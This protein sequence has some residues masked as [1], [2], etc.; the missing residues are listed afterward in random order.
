MT[1]Q[2]LFSFLFPRQAS[3]SH[4]E[5]II[6]G[7]GGI[8][9]ILVTSWMTHIFIGPVAAPYLLAA[10]GASTVLLLGAP[11]S[12]F[13]Q[14]WSFAGGH[15][16]SAAIGITCALYLQNIYLAAGLAVGLSIV[17]MYYLR[18]IHPPGGAT[19]LLTVI[20]DQKIHAMGYHFIIMPVLANV[21]ILLVV[22]LLIN[23]LILRRQYPL[24][25]ALSDKDSSREH[26]RPSVKLSFS[27]EDLASAMKEMNGYIDVT[28]EDLQKIYSLAVV[29]SHQWRLGELRLKDIMTR[30]VVTIKPQQS[31][32][33]VWKLLRRHRI[34]G[35]PVV[36]E[37]N[38][39]LG[40]VSI[41][42]FL[43]VADWRMC[44]TLIARMKLF[45]SNQSSHTV[46]QIMSTPVIVGHENMLLTQAFQLFSEK[47]INHLPLV[48]ESG[49]LVGILTRLD[50]LSSLYGDMAVISHD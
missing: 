46:A 25:L 26:A 40:I 24:N 27:Q 49:A 45:F 22:A 30:E 36:D 34:R 42:D 21:A 15:L 39:L 4:R 43:E 6:S 7:L 28:G 2:A 17:A 12:P 3:L 9:A 47:G 5:R 41:A 35:A 32:E 18:C 14:P 38:K 16:V 8:L 31:L 50:L 19:A 10:M 11:H 1:V 33:D 48:D 29:H 44:N 23:R 20:G 13:S 37:A